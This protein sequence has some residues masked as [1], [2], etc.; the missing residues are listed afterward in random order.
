MASDLT[1]EQQT[2]MT[3]GLDKRCKLLIVPPG[4]E[5]EFLTDRIKIG[6]ESVPMPVGYQVQ[7][8]LVID[9]IDSALPYR[10]VAFRLWH[11]SFAWVEEGRAYP[12]VA[13]EHPPSVPGGVPMREPPAESPPWRPGREWL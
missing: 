9:R 8:A 4:L 10:H 12:M 6:H 1:P 13:W 2:L 5:V 11:H 7:M 3:R